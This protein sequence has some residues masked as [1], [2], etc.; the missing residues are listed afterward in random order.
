MP[1]VIRLTSVCFSAL[2]PAC[3]STTGAVTVMVGTAS[4]FLRFL[5][6]GFA[7]SLTDGDNFDMGDLLGEGTVDKRNF[8]GG[9]QGESR[10]HSLR[11]S[12]SLWLRNRTLG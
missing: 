10:V 8:E 7:T 9:G 4:E 6:G 2:S 1:S 12:Q 5:K 3:L 11:A